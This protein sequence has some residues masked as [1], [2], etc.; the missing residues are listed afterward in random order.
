MKTRGLLGNLAADFC[1]F[2]RF[3]WVFVSKDDCINTPEAYF[4]FE[5]N[6]LSL[7]ITGK[8]QKN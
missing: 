8:R 2:G 1:R 3:N 7:W 4:Y 5:P 6:I